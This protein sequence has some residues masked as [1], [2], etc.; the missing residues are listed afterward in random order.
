MGFA[1]CGSKVKEMLKYQSSYLGVSRILEETAIAALESE[2]YY[3]KL[4]VEIVRDR[5]QFIQEL[6]TFRNFKSYTSKANFVLVRIMKRDIQKRVNERL[7]HEKLII[8]KFVDNDL[9]RVTVGYRKYT[10]KLI[11][12]LRGIIGKD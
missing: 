7:E 1:L 4:S 5:E 6:M 10:K 2:N 12:L 3:K 11:T 8:S 9:L